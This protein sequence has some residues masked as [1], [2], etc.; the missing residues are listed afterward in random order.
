MAKLST[1]KIVTSAS[2]SAKPV[3]PA[4]A[5]AAKPVAVAAP[6]V[7]DVPAVTVAKPSARITRT[8]ATVAAQRTN[9]GGLSDR[10]NA[11]LTFYASLAKAAT[12]GTVTIAGI[13][14]SGRGPDYAGSAKPHDAGVIVRLGKA[15]L[16]TST[17]D[18]HGFTF[19]D[20]ARSLAA[21]ARG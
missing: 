19:T 12:D 10:D 17:A 18:G 8:A 5:V 15:G 11:Y 14:A 6:V 16:L 4:K 21:Y 9:F 3:K 2:T 13:V 1:R 20:S 7:A